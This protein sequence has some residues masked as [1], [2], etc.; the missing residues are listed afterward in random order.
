MLVS[1]AACPSCALGQGR[2]SADGVLLVAA[3]VLLPLVASIVAGLVIGRAVRRHRP[4]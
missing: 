4:E 1:L 3:L 2:D